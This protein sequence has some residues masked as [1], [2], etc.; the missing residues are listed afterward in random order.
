[1]A[2]SKKGRKVEAKPRARGNPIARAV[3][4]KIPDNPIARSMRRAEADTQK[5]V[6][7]IARGLKRKPKKKKDSKRSRAQ[8]QRRRQMKSFDEKTR[9]K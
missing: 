8:A 1:V 5:L 2:E 9:K 4:N 6:D 3:R 7:S